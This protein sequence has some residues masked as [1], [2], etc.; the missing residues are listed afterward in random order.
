MLDE[1]Q[2]SNLYNFLV[3]EIAA[4]EFEGPLD[5]ELEKAFTGRVLYPWLKNWVSDLRKPGLYVRGDGGPSVSPVVWHGINFHPDLGIY[6]G[7]NKFV[8]FEVKL[9]SNSDPGGA[10]TKAVGQTLMYEHLGFERSIGMI[11][12][13]APAKAL[14]YCLSESIEINPRTQ[15]IILSRI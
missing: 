15:V 3:E 7:E 14:N 13:L 10:L 4:R 9:L 11:F 5:D 2:I 12:N 6:S 8:S 1:T